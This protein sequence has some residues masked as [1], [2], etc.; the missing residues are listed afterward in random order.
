MNEL[1]LRMLA[2]DDPHPG[3]FDAY[4]TALAAFSEGATL[5]A[6]LRRFEWN[7]LRESGYA[8]DLEL[9]SN[10][11][12]IRADGW[13]RWLPAS[14]FLVSEPDDSQA[15]AG[16]TLREIATGRY[17]SPGSRQQAKLLTRTIIS[18][19]LNGATIHSRQILIDL[20]KL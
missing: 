17:Q 19:H 18:H 13:Y 7:L 11:A 20:Q 15:V 4:T 6:T 8:P 12:R 5:D 14:G 1:L 10:S 16:A 9:D 3:L 2:R